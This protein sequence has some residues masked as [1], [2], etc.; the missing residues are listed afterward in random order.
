MSRLRLVTS[1]QKLAQ[2]HVA[3]VAR[4]V[5]AAPASRGNHGPGRHGLIRHGL[6]RHGLVRRGVCRSRIG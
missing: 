2:P 1:S 6:I 3:H 4:A 5:K